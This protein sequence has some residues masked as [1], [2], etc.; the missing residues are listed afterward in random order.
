MDSTCPSWVKLQ[1]IEYGSP[2]PNIAL[3]KPATQ[4]S[5]Y[6]NAA[7]NG[8]PAA[9]DGID[10]SFTHTN[11][12]AGINPW[13]R[14]DLED[15]YTITKIEVVNRLDCCGTRL[16]D[17]IIDFFDDNDVQVHSELVAGQN[18][19]RKTL[20]IDQ[21]TARYVKITLGDQ[22]CLQLGEVKIYGYQGSF[23]VESLDKLTVGDDAA[24]CWSTPGSRLM[25]TPDTFKFDDAHEAT[26]VSSPSA[27]VIATLPL[28]TKKTA[29]DETFGYPD[30]AVEVALLDRKMLIRGEKETGDHEKIGAH[31]IVLHTPMIA[32]H[33][34]GVQFTNVGQQTRLGRYPIHFHMS[35]C[36]HGSTV[37]KNVVWQSN[38]RCFVIHG[39]HNVTLS[40]NVA[41]DT[42]GH[43][44]ML[45]DGGEW[46]NKVSW[47]KARSCD[48]HVHIDF[49]SIAY[50]IL[51]PISS[52]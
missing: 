17:Y 12:W 33:L 47:M 25:L 23:P 52:S 43:C 20:S 35:E 29:V 1:S 45:E 15:E 36:V 7:G 5:T 26:V 3:N 18:G 9:V 19:N 13:W 51:C 2:L 41:Y 49:E 42:R 34:E 21:V 14:V 27:G 50:V 8:A 28:P 30:F 46:D 48:V 6:N 4:S 16:H 32:Q 37:A 40:E 39:T 44:Y 31:L 38:Q 11:C 24:R 22:D 10:S